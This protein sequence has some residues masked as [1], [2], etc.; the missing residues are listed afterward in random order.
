MLRTPCCALVCALVLFAST[1][2]ALELTGGW[3]Q[4]DLALEEKGDGVYLGVQEVWPIGDGPF[5]F[6]AAAEYQLRRGLQTFNYTHPDRGLFQEQ[7]EV[8][9]HY[10]QTAGF[11]GVE[12]PVGTRSL[13]F[14]GG[15]SMGIKLDESWDEPEA[16]KGLDLGFEDQDLQLHLGMSFPFGRYLVDARYT[17]GLLEQVIIRDAG[18]ILPDKAAGDELPG[19]GE[20]V[21]I[22]QIGFGVRF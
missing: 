10:L 18:A 14:Y 2:P 9:L 22:M 16:D 6:I 19:G 8:S 1:A 21:N 7:G 3:V 4:A 20:K 11:L 17:A 13:R 12:V 5:I 15:A